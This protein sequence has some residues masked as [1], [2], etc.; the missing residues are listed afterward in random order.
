MNSA[1]IVGQEQRDEAIADA[2]V[3]GRSLRAVRREFGPSVVDAALERLWPID[4]QSRLQMIKSDLGKI[5]RL[6]Q[7]FFEKALAGDVQSGL[8]TVR[9]WERK[10]ELLGM[11]AA[12]KFEVVTRP[13]D[14]PTRYERIHAAIM[15]LGNQQPPA[16]RAAHNLISK[17]GGERALELLRGAL[18]NGDGATVP[19]D[20]ECR[21][22]DG[23][24]S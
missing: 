7:I 5:D 14:A 21:S 2:I 8:L 18:G 3:S 10:H 16:E 11:N 22:A 24:D 17:V 20:P 23:T 15:N 4:T 19:D 1:E 12:A 6:T 9:I 13:P